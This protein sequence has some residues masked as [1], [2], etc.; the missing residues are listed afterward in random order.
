MAIIVKTSRPNWVITQI[1]SRIDNSQIDTWEYDKD[2]DF[3]HVGQWKNLA[4]MSPVIEENCVIFRILGRNSVKM[5]LMEYA[6]FHGRFLE[7]LINQFPDESKKI[8]I[9]APLSNP[10]DNQNIEL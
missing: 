4:W 3:T 6:V 2:G 10:L 9:E 5:T 1:R 8:I 7:M